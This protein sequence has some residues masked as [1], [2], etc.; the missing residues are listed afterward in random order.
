LRIFVY[1]LDLA[2]AHIRELHR[3]AERS[4]NRNTVPS[5]P[6]RLRR[7]TDRVARGAGR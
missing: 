5:H 1:T 2:R 7:L 3:A 6:S 4:H